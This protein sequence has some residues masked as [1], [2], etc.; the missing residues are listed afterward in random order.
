MSVLLSNNAV[1]KL[2]SPLT[3]GATTLLLTAGSGSL[4]PAPAGGNWFPITVMS[5]TTGA[6]EIMRCT[7]RS[8]DTL[9]VTRAQ[10][11]TTA[12]AFSAGDR[13]EL[14]LT[15]GAL[16][17]KLADFAI[18]V[19]NYGAVGDGVT[20]DTAAIQAALNAAPNG[21]AVVIPASFRCYVASSITV[22]TGVALLGL[23]RSWPKDHY[24]L[25]A[26][27]SA[28]ILNS[29]ATI[30][31]SGATALDGLAILR[32]GLTVGLLSSQII[33]TFQGQAVTLADGS[34]DVRIE[35]CTIAGFYTAIA[36]SS[37]QTSHR[38][39]FSN[40]FI[41]C[42]NGVSVTGSADIARIE[43]VH[44]WPIMAQGGSDNWNNI[45]CGLT[46]FNIFGVHDWIKL[47][48]CFAYGYKTGYKLDG[49]NNAVL[50]GCG[51]DYVPTGPT[52]PTA[53]YPE[54]A[55]GT[56]G[57]IG[58]SITGTTGEC[59]FI[60]CQSAASDIGFSFNSSS[61]LHTA[62]MVGC[63]S[64]NHYVA[65][66]DV[67]QGDVHI[68]NY[69]VRDSNAKSAAVATHAS[70]ERIQVNSLAVFNCLYG[71]KQDSTAT[72]LSYSNCNFKSVIVDNR[73]VNPYVPTVAS[74]EPLQLDGENF[75][76]N[77]SGTTNFGSIYGDAD[78]YAGKLV[79]LKFLG[80]LTVLDGG[81]TT[82]LNGNFVTAAGA[83]LTLV[84]DGNAFYEVARSLT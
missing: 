44:C 43:N 8:G 79:T 16:N 71:I 72:V 70:A 83:T 9:T 5:V 55:Y 78:T 57:S 56:D 32:Q 47:T 10:E 24:T 34:W 59:L 46:A 42:R 1:S 76:F 74:H 50:V 25:L 3:A 7:A 12:K 62:Q 6:M 31:M 4:F 27:G 68:G 37:G 49:P 13:V 11:G 28:L 22:P 23:S 84:S 66:A 58:F 80:A 65:G 39:T 54:R 75:V 26:R 33:S 64:W 38:F 81:A 36:N 48:N 40:V 52:G 19:A 77:V 2:A 53:A 69:S 41:D 35:W 67:L 82:K 21:G 51:N 20:D 15:V 29:A 63:Q 30:T 17:S 60:G 14:R 18:S 45:K 61:S 73:V